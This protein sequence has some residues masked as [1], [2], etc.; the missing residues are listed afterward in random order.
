MNGQD[1][2]PPLSA[3]DRLT[4]AEF[5]RRY[6]A[7]PELK[8][9]ELVEGVVYVPSPVSQSRHGHPHSCLAYWLNHYAARTPGS[10]TGDNATVRL[11][12]DNEPQP[13]LLLYLLPVC[14]GRTHLDAGGMLEGPP[15]LVVE[16]TASRASYDLHDKLHAYRRSGVPEYLVWRVDDGDFDWFVLR[17]GRYDRLPEVGGML[18]SEVFPGLWLDV[19]AALRRDLPALARAVEAGTAS[20]EHAAFVGGLRES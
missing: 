6:A 17:D 7:M 10:E 2:I 1:R 19:A 11:D 12:L 9:A 14:G 18:R 20:P 13:D 4:V 16:I 8:K 3:G 5:E 15:E